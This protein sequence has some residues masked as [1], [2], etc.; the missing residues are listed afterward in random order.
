MCYTL[1]RIGGAS[2]KKYRLIFAFLFLFLP[3]LVNADSGYTD[4]ILE[5]SK[6]SMNVTYKNECSVTIENLSDE[7][8]A[9]AVDFKI[10][11]D[12]GLKFKNI[13]IYD[14]WQGTTENGEISLTGSTAGK[15]IFRVLTFVVESDIKEDAIKT[16]KLLNIKIK[17]SDFEENEIDK[18]ISLSIHVPSD[19]N[20]LSMLKIDG[21]NIPNF[22]SNVISFTSNVESNKR[23]ITI[24]AIPTNK[25]ATISGDVGL[26]K[27]KFGMNKFIIKVTSETGNEK[28]YALNINRIEG[29]NLK[30]LSINGEEIELVED[31]YI[32]N[33]QT[34][35][36]TLTISGEL[37][38]PNLVTF[39]TDYG[40]REI[41]DIN[42]NEVLI[43]IKDIS[44]EKDED[45]LVYKILINKTVQDEAVKEEK[46]E[47]IETNEKSKGIDKRLI[48]LAILLFLEIASVVIEVLIL[49]KRNRR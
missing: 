37:E 25:S 43:K 48:I 49:K 20:T 3:I 8:L 1:F 38:N 6:T 18:V 41:K 17:G 4:I 42:D 23:E 7:K 36:D 44:D 32:Y 21:N 46:E 10:K 11:L 19:V 28:E 16:I 47:I 40:F 30:T 33:Y 12:D 34:S 5:C 2:V 45:L 39:V 31:T 9:N 26:K 29:R 35:L 22:N 24:E 14:G 13:E 15:G 27:L